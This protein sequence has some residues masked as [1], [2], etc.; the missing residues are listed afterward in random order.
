MSAEEAASNEAA[1]NIGIGQYARGAHES[2]L[3][4]VI[5]QG[6]DPSVWTGN[7]SVRSVFHAPTPRDDNGQRI[8]SRK[9]DASY[10]KIEQVSRGPFAELYARRRYS[11]RWTVW[12]NQL[13]GT[14]QEK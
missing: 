9:P 10:R 12:G 1:L 13:E 8:H 7:R 3:F 2:L 14:N 11:D 4:G 6:Q 5:G